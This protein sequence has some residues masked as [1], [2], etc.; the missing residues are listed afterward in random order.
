M[1]ILG[2]EARSRVP[3]EYIVQQPTSAN[4]PTLFLAL[5]Q[6]ADQIAAAASDASASKALQDQEQFLKAGTPLYMCL[7]ASQ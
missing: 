7:S 5:A 1:Q 3:E 4:P 6:M 2:A